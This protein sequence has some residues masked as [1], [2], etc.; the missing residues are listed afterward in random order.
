MSTSVR[1]IC[2]LLG[3]AVLVIGSAGGQ[4]IKAALMYG[5]SHVDG[6]E[7]VDAVVELGKTTYAQYIGD[8]FHH[9]KVNV[10]VGEGR[11]YLR[12]S[13][14]KY[15]IIQIFSN[16]TSSSTG[17]GTGAMTPFWRG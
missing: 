16:H 7:L 14:E 6:V 2:I 1:R 9:P 11:S 15:D 8:L 5:A 4:E 10:Q 17:S 3:A 12:A 13:Q